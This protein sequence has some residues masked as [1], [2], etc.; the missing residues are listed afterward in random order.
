MIE[1]KGLMASQN[2]LE[3]SY[4]D[5]YINKKYEQNIGDIQNT[6][7]YQINQSWTMKKYFMLTVHKTLPKNLLS[8][9]LSNMVLEV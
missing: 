8:S 2:E 3:D 4:N 1:Y 9:Y 7:K 5:W 6:I